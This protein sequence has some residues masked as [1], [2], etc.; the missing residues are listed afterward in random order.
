MEIWW[1]KK[2]IRGERLVLKTWW[3]VGLKNRNAVG[4][5]L[6][7]LGGRWFPKTSGKFEVET[8]ATPLSGK[9]HGIIIH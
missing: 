2:E 5:E 7:K 4:G 3:E 9:A 1:R 8:T 6:S